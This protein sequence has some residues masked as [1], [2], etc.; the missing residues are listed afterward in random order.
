MVKVVNHKSAE[1]RKRHGDLA[2]REFLQD[3]L[4]R[5]GGSFERADSRA[6]LPDFRCR[7]CGLRVDVKVQFSSPSPSISQIPFDG[8]PDNLVVARQTGP[9]HWTGAE[10]RTLMRCKSGLFPATHS[11]RATWFYRF[12]AS[13][14]K[15]LD[16]LLRRSLSQLNLL[17]IAG[18]GQE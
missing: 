14:F 2:E 8:Y 11:E 3:W 12:P 7:D 4:C 13:A 15:P 1:E 16:T 6:G 18:L 10:K 9:G 5:C 17:D